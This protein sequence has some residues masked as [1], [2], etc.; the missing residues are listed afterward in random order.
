MSSRRTAERDLVEVLELIRWAHVHGY[1]PEHATARRS[2]GPVTQPQGDEVAGPRWDFGIGSH[3]ARTALLR[4]SVPVLKAARAA[5]VAQGL[6]DPRST[7]SGPYTCRA[8]GQS[9]ASFLAELVLH[10][11][12][13]LE[14]LPAKLP[15]RPARIAAERADEAAWQARRIL[16]SPWGGK[17]AHQ[18]GDARRLCRIC[19]IRPRATEGR[20]TT[21]RAW[22][23]RH[24]TERPRSRDQ[25]SVSDARRAQ[26]RRR[27]RGEGW[28][29][30]SLSATRTEQGASS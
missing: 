4:A 22:F 9:T 3:R 11:L 7:R 27:R 5:W 28:G 17:A 30:E 13:N 24:G 6:A 8:H 15:N 25:D 21:C 29:D 19:G 2:S 20:C 23:I 10:A 26:G 12:G 14:V 18:T 16:E 1:T